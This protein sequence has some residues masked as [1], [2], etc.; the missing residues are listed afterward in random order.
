MSESGRSFHA[1]AKPSAVQRRSGAGGNRTAVYVIK[2]ETGWL[3]RARKK[4][5]GTG[6]EVGRGEGE[7][8][9]RHEGPRRREM[10][11]CYQGDSRVC[12]SDLSKVCPP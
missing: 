10:S 1:L 4:S 3:L 5:S 7:R 8:A 11:K 12:V 9:K 2:G 6:R